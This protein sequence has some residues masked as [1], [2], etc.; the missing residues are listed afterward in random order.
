MNRKTGE[1][2]LILSSE[3]APLACFRQF[4]S[5]ASTFPSQL[6]QIVIYSSGNYV[7]H[8]SL[9]LTSP[10]PLYLPSRLLLTVLFAFNPSQSSGSFPYGHRLNRQPER[11]YKDC[12]VEPPANI[13]NIK[14]VLAPFGFSSSAKHRS[15]PC[16]VSQI[17]AKP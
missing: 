1:A 4:N 3:E 12:H 13:N 16:L 7:H 9:R 8:N 6:K 14:Y 15:F 10:A 2:Q 17:E 11:I 5:N